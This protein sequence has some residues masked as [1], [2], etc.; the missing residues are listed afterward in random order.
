M[1]SCMCSRCMWHCA[2][3]TD[4]YTRRVRRNSP[5]VSTKI[6]FLSQRTRFLSR[7]IRLQSIGKNGR[8]FKSESAKEAQTASTECT[9]YNYSAWYHYC[10]WPVFV[11]WTDSETLSTE[12]LSETFMQTMLSFDITSYVL[13]GRRLTRENRKVFATL[14][15]P[16]TG[17]L[18]FVIVLGERNKWIN[19]VTY[20]R[21]HVRCEVRNIWN[22]RWFDWSSNRGSPIIWSFYWEFPQQGKE[23]LIKVVSC[24]VSAVE[25]MRREEKDSYITAK[26]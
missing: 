17:C 3:W 14:R 15:Y 6:R 9:T 26:H 1:V 11:R 5:R 4:I 23:T 12:R 8:P 7:R 24:R 22:I 19:S 18:T 20:R 16:S 25:M 2:W 13:D 10:A 21:F